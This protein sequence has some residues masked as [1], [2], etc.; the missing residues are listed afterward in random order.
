MFDYQE[1]PSHLTHPQ[2]LKG[3]PAQGPEGILGECLCTYRWAWGPGCP[4]LR[5][6]SASLALEALRIHGELPFSESPVCWPGV[7]GPDWSAWPLFLQKQKPEGYQVALEEV[8]P[9]L[10]QGL[11]PTCCGQKAIPF[12]TVLISSHPFEIR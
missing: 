4:G 2:T 3:K 6:L 7:G 11:P 1:E 9:V 5:G 12:P 8:N 10:S